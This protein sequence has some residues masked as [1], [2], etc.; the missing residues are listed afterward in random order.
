M[1]G[2]SHSLVRASSCQEKYQ[3]QIYQNTQLEPFCKHLFSTFT[4]LSVEGKSKE[5]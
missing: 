3:V 4:I 1:H 2:V 5:L